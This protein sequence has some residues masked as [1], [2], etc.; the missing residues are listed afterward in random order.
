M[1]KK[2]RTLDE[3]PVD[4]IEAVKRGFIHRGLI[5]RKYRRNDPTSEEFVLDKD[6]SE[7]GRSPDKT[8][9]A[10]SRPK[11]GQKPRSQSGES[12]EKATH[13]PLNNSPEDQHNLSEED[14][15]GDGGSGKDQ[16]TY[17]H[18][19][20]KQGRIKSSN[21]PDE[22][23][24]R[25]KKGFQQVEPQDSSGRQNQ[26][27]TVEDEQRKEKPEGGE[28]GTGKDWPSQNLRNDITSTDP[29][30]SVIDSEKGSQEAA[31]D[32]EEPEPGRTHEKLI[33]I[34]EKAHDILFEA[35]TVFP[36]T[37]FPDTITLDREK[38]TIANRAF[39]RI[40]KIIT[41]PVTSMISAEADV[42]PFFGMVRMTSKYFIDNTHEVKFLWRQDATTVH[43]LLQGFIIA[44][45]RG[46]ELHE[47]DKDDLCVLLEDL[48]QGVSD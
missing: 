13:D 47:I 35:D 39:F 11:H 28:G 34:T 29:D 4:V 5:P 21:K 46:L 37:L 25:R 9:T 16:P 44:H 3:A 15:H 18:D 32:P 43:R 27:E 30:V 45:E 10:N 1:S 6:E 42:G 7:K 48:G 2:I 14:G 19:D 41:V 26:Q 24:G 8:Q 33:D 31:K 36:F 17:K 40:A 22:K 12:G 23:I 20:N 38:L